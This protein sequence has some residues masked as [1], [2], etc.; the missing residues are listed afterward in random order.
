MLSLAHAPETCESL[1]DNRCPRV[2]P[3]L[4][5][6]HKIHA[7]VGYR[8]AHSMLCSRKFLEVAGLARGL[9]GRVTLV[10]PPDIWA[11][12][13]AQNALDPVARC[14]DTERVG[15]PWPSQPQILQGCL[16]GH[17]CRL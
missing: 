12:I 11:G 3:P 13:R 8:R 1:I 15:R 6:F 4:H 16:P 5:I 10:S 17:R 2:A 9:R 14:S 7:R